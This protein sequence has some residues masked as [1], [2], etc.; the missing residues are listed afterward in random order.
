MKFLV[1]PLSITNCKSSM[2]D[3]IYQDLLSDTRRAA[4][5]ARFGSVEAVDDGALPNVGQ[6]NDAHCDGRLDALVAAVVA[7]QTHKELRANAR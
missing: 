3:S 5:I 4:N 6:P 2:S 7:Q 1:L